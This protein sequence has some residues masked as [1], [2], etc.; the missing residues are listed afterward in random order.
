MKQNFFVEGKSAICALTGVFASITLLLTGC[1]NAA[2]DSGENSTAE[3]NS[4]DNVIYLA[5]AEADYA[6]VAKSMDELVSDSDWI[7]EIRVTDVSS[8]VFE[9]T[10][11][12]HTL[13][14]PEVIQTY[15]GSYDG[16][17]LEVYGGYMNY[18]AYMD[19]AFM[20]K[21]DTFDV[22]DIS[23]E[24][25]ETGE[26][27]YNA[28]NSHIPEKGETLLF[29]GR[30]KEDGSG[31]VV[32]NNYQG[33]FLCDGDTLTNP[34]LI[35]EDASG[36]QEPLVEDILG[37]CSQ[38]NIIAPLSEACDQAQILSLS[39]TEFLDKIKAVL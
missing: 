7:A 34:A 30:Q 35:V 23:E 13:I 8:C 2:A 33:L 39:R 11:E 1:G 15:Y 22:G 12:I 18:K 38:A 5:K 16:G 28:C 17:T 37:Q 10:D 26:I 14:T 29:F 25:L 4:H 6:H 36:W 24:K 20:S 27:Y 21:Y 19:E 9:G 32:T 31:Y 3:K